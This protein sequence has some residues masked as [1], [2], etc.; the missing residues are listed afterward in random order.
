MQNSQIGANLHIHPVN[1]VA[2]RFNEDVRP[3]EG[4]SPWTW[5]YA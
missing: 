4:K 1:H 2:A 3:W 5:S